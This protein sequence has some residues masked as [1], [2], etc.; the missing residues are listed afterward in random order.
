MADRSAAADGARRTAPR[1]LRLM[2]L[3]TVQGETDASGRLVLE[4]AAPKRARRRARRAGVAMKTVECTYPDS[5]SRLGGTMNRSA[6]EALRRDVPEVLDGFAWLAVRYGEKVDVARDSVQALNDVS[7]LGVTLPLPLL[8]SGTDPMAEHGELP[9][10]VASVF[11]ASRGIFSAAFDLLHEPGAPRTVTADEFVRFAEEQGHLQG[12]D[13]RNVC[14]APTRLITRTIA[15]I[16]TG[17]GAD[18]DRSSL[19]EVLDFEL[20]WELFCMERGFSESLSQY[21]N[22]LQRLVA[23]GAATSPQELFSRTVSH[24]GQKLPFGELT[25]SF[26]EYANRIQRDMNDLLG[27]DGARAPQVTF[28]DVMQAL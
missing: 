24:G 16:L 27:R 11:K 2:D 1:G 9:P 20:L 17:E 23:S 7:K 14:A 28:Q 8:R 12:Q 15:A 19:P 26:L 13:T 21:G 10:F 22:V 25:D 3:L 4:D 18:P 6:Y 5:P